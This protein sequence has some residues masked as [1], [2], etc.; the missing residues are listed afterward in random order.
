MARPHT[1][2]STRRRRSFLL[3]A[4]GFLTLDVRPGSPGLVAPDAWLDSWRGI[5][6]I[7][8][9]MEH[10]GYALRLEKIH[11][12]GWRA[13]FYTDPRVSAVDFATD[14]Q[15]WLVVQRAA[16]AA[17]RRKDASVRR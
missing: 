15:P 12:D 9:G 1:K 16:W 5:D 13:S 6:T 17:V 7:V 8:V 4:L 14:P 2:T 11:G 10:Q 3:A